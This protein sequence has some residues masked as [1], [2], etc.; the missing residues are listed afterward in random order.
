MTWQSL[1]HD[2]GRPLPPG[3]IGLHTH[4]A[5]RLYLQFYLG[6]LQLALEEH[7]LAEGRENDAAAHPM[8]LYLAVVAKA[9]KD[10]LR[11]I[12]FLNAA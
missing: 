3:C 8:N 9:P 12:D 6:F 11:K 7:R 2:L 5:V 10:T 1:G 4:I